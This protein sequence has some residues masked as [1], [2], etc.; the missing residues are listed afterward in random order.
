VSSPIVVTIILVIPASS[1]TGGYDYWEKASAQ[2]RAMWSAQAPSLPKLM[3][4]DC[5]GQGCSVI[6][7]Q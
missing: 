3:S 1:T 2:L 4:Y 7:A 5:A 6:V